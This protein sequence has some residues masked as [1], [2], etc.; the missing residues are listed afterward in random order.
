MSTTRVNRA[1]EAYHS[2]DMEAT[3]KAHSHEAFDKEQNQESYGDYLGDM[4]YGALDGIVTT[5]AVVAGSSGA[6]LGAGIIIVLG[7]A[8]LLADG[9]SM[10][11]G[12]Y[13]SMKSEQDYYRAEKKRET[14]EVENYPEGEVEEIKQIYKR[15][16]YTGQNLEKL[17]ELITSK[18]TV[19]VDTMMVNELG[20]I[21]ES[22]DPLKAGAYTLASFLIVGFVPMI[23]FVLALFVPIDSAI[24][25]PVAIVLT[26]ITIFVVGSLRSLVIA[27]HWFNAGLEMFIVGGLTAVVSYGIGVVLGGLVL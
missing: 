21:D 2:K 15:K 5:F 25:F 1:R 14:W 17:V 4:V 8:N 23:I 10:A 22:K 6:G 24:T 11:V 3:K 27:K 19:W 7:F 9:L 20:M 18:K 12:N 26:F 13:L 16:G